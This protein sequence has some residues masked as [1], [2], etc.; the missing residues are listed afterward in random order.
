MKAK[1]RYN[2][3]LRLRTAEAAKLQAVFSACRAV[4]NQALGRWVELH[5]EEGLSYR[6]GDADK[7]LTDWRSAWPWLAGQP[8]V[9]EQQV[10]RDLF[11]SIAAFFDKAN[12]AGRPRFKSRKAGYAT[13]RWTTNGFSVSGSGLGRRADRLEVAVAG[14]RLPLRVVWSRP[15]P[16]APTSVTVRRDKAGHWWASFVVEVE[17]PEAP[18]C[19]TGRTTGLDMGL[20]TFATAEDEAADV[21]NPRFARR[22]ATALARSQRNVARA[23][24]GSKGRA[25]AKKRL[26]AAS[27]KVADQRRDFQHKAAR[28]LLGAYDVVGVEDLQVKNMSRRAKLARNTK[29]GKSGRCKAGLNRS[30][31]DAGWRQFLSVLSWQAAKAGKRVMVLPA[32]GTT[33]RCSS[34]GARAKPRVELSDRVFRCGC[35]GLVLGRD[36]NA[37][38]NL[39]P[40]RAP[41]PAGWAVPARGA[42]GGDDGSK[43]SVLASAGA[44]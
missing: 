16:S 12:P 42:P 13:A 22:V 14:G 26:A 43:P 5:R 10:L 30:I 2:Y 20:S 37:A 17:L 31:A 6:Y 38:R 44:A 24:K 36:R 33:Q 9:P 19:P 4:W 27:A 11:K 32:G 21:A 39:N 25:K 15:L 8:S 35:C 41:G 28:G 23:Q 3:R 40:G 18:T 7:E 29:R 34:C 1:A